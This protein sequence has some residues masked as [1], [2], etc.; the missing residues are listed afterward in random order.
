MAV[1]YCLCYFLFLQ[2]TPIE[3]LLTCFETEFPSAGIAGGMETYSKRH[4][5][6]RILSVVGEDLCWTS[7][8]GILDCLGLE[9]FLVM[10]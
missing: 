8:K 6:C 2:Q 7:F 3:L 9:K 1:F 5:A 10:V 4:V